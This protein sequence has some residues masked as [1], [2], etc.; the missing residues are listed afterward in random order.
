MAAVVV[1]AILVVTVGALAYAYQQAQI[2]K[3]QQE[4][5][6]VAAQLGWGYSAVDH[7]GCGDLA[8]SLLF[9]GDDQ[10]TCNVLWGTTQDGREARLFD[11]WYEEH[12][13]DTQGRKH[14]RRYDFSCAVTDLGAR[15]PH[16]RVAGE[17]I[18]R[19]LRDALGFK[20]HQLESDEFNRRWKVSCDDARFVHAFVDPTVMAFLLDRG[21]G[22]RYEVN[23]S[24][25]LVATDRLD[26]RQLPSLVSHSD[27]LRACMPPVAWELYP[28]RAS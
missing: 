11:F 4:V 27:D 17:S 1:I 24:L 14:T 21:E 13:R 23:G 12:H 15:F 26:P 19:G 16:L 8:F 20:D 22:V 25:L 9:E 7:L 3:R 10:G 28:E 18:F 6:A 5:A 2:K